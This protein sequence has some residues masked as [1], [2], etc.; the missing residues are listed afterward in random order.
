LSPVVVTYLA[1][2]PAMVRL[3]DQFVVAAV[4][5]DTDQ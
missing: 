3:S 5:D 1:Q 4:G 2:Q